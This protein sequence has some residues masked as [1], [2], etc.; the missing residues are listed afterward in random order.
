VLRPAT[1]TKLHRWIEADRAVFPLLVKRPANLRIEGGVSDEALEIV[2]RVQPYTLPDPESHPLHVLHRL[3]SVDRHR[4]LHLTALLL[5][6]SKVFLLPPDRSSMVGGQ[7]Q[8]GPLGDDGIIGAF[9]FAGGTADP[10]LEVLASGET[11]VA[12]GDSGPRPNDRSVLLV[13]EELVIYVSMTLVPMFEP[14]LL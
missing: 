3:W 1:G 10:D 13:L 7:F 12:L 2:N 9:L 8:S 6:D 14:H 5:R 4:N 11:I